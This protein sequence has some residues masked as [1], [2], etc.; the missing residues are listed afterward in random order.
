MMTVFKIWDYQLITFQ[1]DFQEDGFAL[2]HSRKQADQD[3]SPVGGQVVI[4]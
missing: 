4:S 3:L 2:Y 1:I